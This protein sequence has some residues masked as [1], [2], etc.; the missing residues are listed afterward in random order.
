MS[1]FIAEL[2][3]HDSNSRGKRFRHFQAFADCAVALTGSARR[4]PTSRLRATRH[5]ETVVTSVV[6]DVAAWFTDAAR[7]TADF[8]SLSLV[9]RSWKISDS[10]VKD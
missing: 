3:S 9:L 4:V 7:E 6:K 8:S 1:P 5:W 10:R 2:S